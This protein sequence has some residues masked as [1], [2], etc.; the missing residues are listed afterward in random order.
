MYEIRTVLLDVGGI[1]HLPAH[2]P[3]LGA[4]ARA[5]APTAAERIDRAHYAGAAT[6]S[7]DYEGE[8]P[9]ETM[10]RAYL[11]AYAR[12]CGVPDD[13]LPEAVDHLGSE[14]ATG[15]L[16]A[17]VVPGSVEA[18]RELAATGVTLGIV[19]NADGAVGVR[20]AEQEVL[21]VGPGPG[22][23]VATVIDSGVV[24]VQKPDPRIF[25][26]ALDALDA[27]A[28][29]TVYVGDMPAIDVVG[30]RNAGLR[31]LLMDPFGFQAGVDCEKVA[32]LT[33]VATLVSS[34]G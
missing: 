3:I 31:P 23:R 9:W 12:E 5:D 10:W 17:R 30:A 33:D 1:F 22:V 15:A 34:S 16:W 21:Q 13:R 11:D 2:E 7:P 19:S 27:D 18:L 25:R 20:L 24:G 28:D 32:S 4:L 29:T 8:L 6:F 14:F 26:L